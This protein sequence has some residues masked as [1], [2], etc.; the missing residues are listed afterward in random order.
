MIHAEVLPLASNLH[1]YFSS[2]VHDIAH[3]LEVPLSE[4]EFKK[5]IKHMK[6][7]KAPVGL[8]LQHNKIFTDVLK[9]RFLASVSLK[10][11]IAVTPTDKKDAA[12]VSNCS[13]ISLR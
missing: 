1:A 3:K 7:G 5:T 2:Q 12:L 11:H 9:L 10:A 6:V 4:T 13:L 8:P